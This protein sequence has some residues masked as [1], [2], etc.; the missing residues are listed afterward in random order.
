MW[1][2][3]EQEVRKMSKSISINIHC[4]KH[5]L[6]GSNSEAQLHVHFRLGRDSKRQPVLWSS[7]GT[8]CLQQPSWTP[9]L[10]LLQSSWLC[11][12]AGTAS[13]VTKMAA[14]PMGEQR[15]SK[16]FSSLLLFATCKNEHLS[17]TV[18]GTAPQQGLKIIIPGVVLYVIT[19]PN[20][21]Q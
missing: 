3:K 6:Q 1:Q 21:N 20:H 18:Q 8:V 14:V 7:V 9:L 4:V 2:L 19:K 5:S 11:R 13:R 12:S 17:L 16:N 15:T 10:Q